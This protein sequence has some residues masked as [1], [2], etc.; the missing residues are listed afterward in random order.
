MC[1][2]PHQGL[3]CFVIGVFFIVRLILT[4]LTI[5]QPFTNKSSAIKLEMISC[6]FVDSFCEI[7]CAVNNIFCHKCFTG[8]S[9]LTRLVDI[10]STN[11]RLHC[12]SRNLNCLVSWQKSANQFQS[13]S[14]TQTFQVSSFCNLFLVKTVADVPVK[15]N[16]TGN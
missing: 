8:Q 3:K 2:M 7:N 14:R 6:V 10:S 15:G 4:S 9:G 1:L 5:Y 12:Y 16:F 11:Y 13:I